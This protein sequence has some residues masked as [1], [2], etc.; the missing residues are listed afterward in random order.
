M[1]NIH[2]THD[3]VSNNV[4]N[5]ALKCTNNHL[6]LGINYARY[7]SLFLSLTHELAEGLSQF[8]PLFSRVV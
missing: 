1:M 3:N 2:Y 6:R 8:S 7:F 4:M 5:C